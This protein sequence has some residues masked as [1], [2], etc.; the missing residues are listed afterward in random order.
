MLWAV[1]QLFPALLDNRDTQVF[2]SWDPPEKRVTDDHIGL[3][4]DL[5]L[6]WL[7]IR[8]ATFRI[9]YLILSMIRF[10]SLSPA[11]SQIND[12]SVAAIPE[13]CT[14]LEQIHTEFQTVVGQFQQNSQ[15]S[16][17]VLFVCI[18][19]GYDLHF[20]QTNTLEI[21]YAAIPLYP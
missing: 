8:C 16:T 11:L 15:L 18:K 19:T 12:P 9:L 21:H 7:R 10:L 3:L 1:A 13:G 6:Q 5:D 2:E 20:A 4:F 14:E 17:K